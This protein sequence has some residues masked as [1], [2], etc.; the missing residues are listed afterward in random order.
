MVNST[1]R[2]PTKRRAR[3]LERILNIVTIIAVVVL[4]A[5]IALWRIPSQYQIYLPATAQSVTPMIAVDGHPAKTGRGDL[6]MTFVAEPDS[7]LLEELLA[8]FDPDATITPL[9]PHYSQSQ[10]QT[11]NHQLMLSSEDTAILVA[12]CRDGY[13]DLC[14]GGLAVQA[15][16]PYSKATGI[17]KAGDVITAVNGTATIT[18]DELR[19]AIGGLRPGAIMSLKI[20]RANKTLRVHVQTISSPNPPHQTVVGIAFVPA[21]PFAFPAKLPI[22]IKINSGS[23]GG[24]SAGLMFTLGILNRLSSTDLTHGQRIAGTGVINLDGTV[25][26][27]GG[28][29]QKVIGA[30]WSG[31]RYFF[32]PCDGGNYSDATRVVGHKM[33]LVPVNTL[34]DALGF[35]KVLGPHGPPASFRFAKCAAPAQ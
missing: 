17:L 35:L 3:R 4:V 2:R 30:Q 29:K 16:E 23:I 8:H 22:G 24:P 13:K 14:S 10:D 27:I 6:L 26:A 34:D 20:V 1:L 12:L 9:P 32:I 15:I 25:S 19:A 21:P 28:V 7:N 11:A 33:T 31:A 18:A 5:V